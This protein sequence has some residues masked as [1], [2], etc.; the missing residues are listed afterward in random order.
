MVKAKR[1]KIAG[2]PQ[3]HPKKVKISSYTTK[4]G[5][6]VNSYKARRWL[7]R[8]GKRIRKV[9]LPE[10][11]QVELE[12]KKRPGVSRKKRAA[13]RRGGLASAEVRR[14]KREE[15][16]RKQLARALGPAIESEINRQ[17]IIDQLQADRVEAEKQQFEIEDR[18]QE[19][20]RTIEDRAARGA[21]IEAL[22]EERRKREEEQE[23]IDKRIERYI[24]PTREKRVALLLEEE[25][26]RITEE[27]RKLEEE[28]KEAEELA[29][30]QQKIYD[31]AA[32]VA[33]REE[34]YT[35]K[36]RSTLIERER[37][38]A[39][40]RYDEADSR[41]K[42]LELLINAQ[43]EGF[44]E[45][46][47]KQKKQE[48]ENIRVIVDSTRDFL[49]K[50]IQQA[51]IPPSPAFDP[52]DIRREQELYEAQSRI[53]ARE[54]EKRMDRINRLQLQIDSTVPSTNRYKYILEALAEDN[55]TRLRSQNVHLEEKPEGMKQRIWRRLNR[56]EKQEYQNLEVIG[57]STK[58]LEYLDH[59]LNQVN[60][61]EK[62][63][64][65]T[66]QEVTALKRNITKTRQKIFD[67]IH[68]KYS[69]P[70]LNLNNVTDSDLNKL[71]EE[72]TIAESLAKRYQKT[73]RLG[74]L[75]Q[76]LGNKRNALESEKLKRTTIE[77]RNRLRAVE[78]LTDYFN[79]NVAA[80]NFDTATINKNVM[81]T[82]KES[83]G[84]ADKRLAIATDE[85]GRAIIGGGEIEQAKF[86]ADVSRA[87]MDS[88]AY[89]GDE[90]LEVKGLRT[91]YREALE[92]REP[93]I[94]NRQIQEWM[95][96]FPEIQW[97]AGQLYK[98]EQLADDYRALGA[99]ATL[100]S[101][102]EE[103]VARA[104]PVRRE[105]PDLTFG[106]FSH[107]DEKKKSH[108]R[109]KRKKK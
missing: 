36:L 39:A 16:S 28:R 18:I 24:V 64:R 52:S 63:G 44:S 42:Q 4:H 51:D 74:N 61:A 108:K 94:S 91:A 29:I 25:Q 84:I 19:A 6:H 105:R 62:R 79:K 3:Y 46:E 80:R 1:I 72:Y 60:E 47:L 68:G 54:Y 15:A 76:L 53:L 75:P 14:R 95:R 77:N 22:W 43:E 34:A 59:M 58:Q 8:Q 83:A 38:R 10:H 57:R 31:E 35:T 12:R 86:K 100:S 26:K 78:N 93:D 71:I 55:D 90:S 104:I 69:V 82:W 41:L 109:S 40:L 92:A 101:L 85:R 66:E 67:R 9:I 13:A 73:N 5:K 27:R 106:L 49:E 98:E 96:L 30:R 21:E 81:D 88:V 87:I 32:K 48:V 17:R 23:E 99:T 103:E 65:W 20:T 107:H 2:Q 11:S 50:S 89:T 56:Q 97:H 37:E 70:E 33:A 45:S 102:S 7:K